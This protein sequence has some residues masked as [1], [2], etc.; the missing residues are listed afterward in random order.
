LQSLNLFNY[1]ALLRN[2]SNNKM[3][4]YDFKR[5]TIIWKRKNQR[6]RERKKL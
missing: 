1:L 6:A 5:K 3:R 2:G 4:V